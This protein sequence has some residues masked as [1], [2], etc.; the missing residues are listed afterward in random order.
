[1][2][3]VTNNSPKKSQPWYVLLQ[4]KQAAGCYRALPGTS[5]VLLVS[6]RCFTAA[7]THW[8]PLQKY[9]LGDKPTTAV[10]WI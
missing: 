4:L 6:V 8:A 5:V 1:M 3:G 9:K 7:I 10:N 2:F